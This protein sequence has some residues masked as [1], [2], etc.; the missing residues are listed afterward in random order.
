MFLN[1]KMY[2]FSLHYEGLLECGLISRSWGHS[3][4]PCLGRSTD[5]MAEASLGG[6]LWTET[7][8]TK[9]QLCRSHGTVGAKAPE[10]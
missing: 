10:H 1:V 5:G 4:G 2:S 9:S 7:Q 3:R 8:R 6:A